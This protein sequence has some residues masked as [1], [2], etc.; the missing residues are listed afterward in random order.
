MKIRTRKQE[1]AILVT[2]MVVCAVL[3]ITLGLTMLWARDHNYYMKRSQAW[4]KAIPV[5]EAGIEEALAHLHDFPDNRGVNGWKISGSYHYKGRDIGDDAKYYVTISNT[6]PVIVSQGSV[7]VPLK[8]ASW[9]TRTVKVTT[10]PRPLFPTSLATKNY[11]DL[12]GNNVLVDSFDSS[13]NAYSTGGH[14]D[15]TKRKDGGNVSVNAGINNAFNAGNANIYGKVAV[16]SGGTVTVGPNGGIGSTAWHNAGNNG[17]ES[18]WVTY[19]ANVSFPAI[20]DAPASGL[21]PLSGTVGGVGYQYILSGGTYDVSQLSGGAFVAADSILI[22][23]DKFSIDSSKAIVLATNATL[24]VYC[25]AP[26]AT[27]TGQGLVNPGT[28]KNFLYFGMPS[29]TSM[30]FNGLVNFIGVV[31]AP[32]ANIKMGGGGNAINFQGAVMG[33]SLTLGG[34][35]NMHYDESLKNFRKAGYIVVTWNEI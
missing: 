16:G 2:T 29:N 1:G 5:L 3:G 35:F 25:Y 17:I 20:D 26:D 15:V 13:T 4:N 23:R 33:K 19:D 12:N 8:S 11:V 21:T 9:I 31:Y 14:Y 6:P 18:G 28:G 34:G 27:V 22:V 7:K 32:D 24:K 10:I 30:N